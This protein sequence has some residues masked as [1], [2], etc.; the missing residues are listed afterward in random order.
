MKVFNNTQEKLFGFCGSI[1]AGCFPYVCF[2][3]LEKKDTGLLATRE[4]SGLQEGSLAGFVSGIITAVLGIIGV[5]FLI[6]IVYGGFMWM[7]SQGD[8]TKVKKARELLY[9]AILGLIIVISA[10][11]ITKF[12]LIDT[13]IKL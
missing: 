7:I 12:V 11:A 13:L 2:A 1:L 3:A 4:A 9:Y 5:V 6:L 8:D 10:G